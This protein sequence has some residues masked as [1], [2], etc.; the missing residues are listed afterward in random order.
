MPV[1]DLVVE[2]IIKMK[3]YLDHL[4]KIAPQSYREYLDDSVK[5]FAVERLIQLL[6]DQA[7]DLNNIILAHIKKPPATDYFSSFINLAE[8]H[9]LEESFARQI[10]PSTGLRNR[11]VHE[12]ERINEEIVFQSIGRMI[13][14]YNLYMQEINKFVNKIEE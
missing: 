7:L 6:V 10:A 14:L 8:N 4:D 1:Q 2:K 3:E 5:K 12:Y 13:K 9:I 11:L